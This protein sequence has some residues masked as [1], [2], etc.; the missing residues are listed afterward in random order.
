MTYAQQKAVRD[1]QMDRARAR[2]DQK[3]WREFLAGIRKEFHHTGRPTPAQAE[4]LR[5]LWTAGKLARFIG[6]A[7]EHGLNPNHAIA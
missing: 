3:A 5:R 4:T 1:A 2:R 7:R 6:Y